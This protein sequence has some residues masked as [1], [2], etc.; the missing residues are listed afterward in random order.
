[1]MLNTV[2]QG[3]PH[4]FDKEYFNFIVGGVPGFGSSCCGL[5]WKEATHSTQPW[6]YAI[7]GHA[8]LR[9]LTHTSDIRARVPDSAHA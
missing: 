7:T 6:A 1:M 8:I 9:Y 3:I 4:S 2:V 5:E